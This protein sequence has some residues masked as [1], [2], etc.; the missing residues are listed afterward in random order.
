MLSIGKLTGPASERYYVSKV[1]QGLDDYYAGRGEAPGRWAGWA[2][3]LLMETDQDVTPEQLGAMLRGQS[4]TTGEVLGNPSRRTVSGFDLTFRAPK[5]VS[6]V[7]GLADQPI[8][9][10]ARDAHDAAVRDALGYLERNA[11]W[12]RR[13]TNGTEHLRGSGFLAAAFR[14]RTSRA[15]DPTLH[16]HVVVANATQAAGRWSTLDGRQLY[17]HAKTAGYLY[18]ATLRAELTRNLGV[19]WEA[20]HNGVADISG[21]PR[22]VIEHFSQR[23]AA[24]L[25]HMAERGEH[26]AR[27]AQIATLA[28]RERKETIAPLD[29]LRDEWR[30]RAAEHGFVRRD[31]DALLDRPGRLMPEAAS[32]DGDLPELTRQ[33]S[34]FDRRHV[35]QAFAERASAVAPAAELE[36]NA[37]AWLDSSRAVALEP[38]RR[39]SDLQRHS[40]PEMI[41]IEQ[42]LMTR[43]RGSRDTG[44][45]LVAAEHVETVLAKRPELSDE[46]ADMTR[47]LTGSGHGIEIV[48]APAGTGK[49][50]ALDAA[51]D[52]WQCE[53]LHVHGCALS[54]RAAAELHDQTG[55]PSTT[56]A[57]LQLDLR[58][59]HQL[60]PD[61]VLVVD[62]AGMV[63]TRDIADLANHAEQANAKLVLCG[64]DRQLPEIAAGGAFRALADRYG[65]IELHEVHRQR[66]DWDR[67]ALAEL[68]TGRVEDWATA[69]REHDRI[70]TGTNAHAVRARLVA[71]WQAARTS[72]PEE[73]AIMLAHRRSDVADLNERARAQLCAAGQL[74]DDELTTA[75]RS[76]AVGDRVITCRN[77]RHVDVINGQRGTV[78]AVDLDR[79]SLTITR[80]DE[81]QVEL[82]DSYLADRHLDHAY[83]MT[84]HRAQGITVDRAFVLG[85]DE[86]YREW[87]YT[88]LS[89]HREE[90]R[91]YVNV[92]ND[93]PT[94]DDDLDPAAE[95]LRRRERKTLAIDTADPSYLPDL[96]APPEMPMPEIPSIPDQ[97]DID[98]GLDFGL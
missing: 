3:D 71:D 74:G 98:T 43:A 85:S 36:A 84:A 64:D 23:R 95:T 7:F 91:F 87:G 18:Q 17:R 89:R 61:S 39:P 46:Q 97:L 1:A 28:T 83:A 88:A 57:R 82:P 67:A 69:Y 49:T 16:S 75:G 27:A 50:F 21:I 62:E 29:R 19:E 38:V 70:V 59:G 58:H 8:A 35:L 13:G 37:D 79:C 65:A 53:G 5:S 33:S 11:C 14:H 92:G 9:L 34:T 86:L 77:D 41:A 76:F 12:T 30:A 66:N 90:A 72:H 10:A 54:A 6:L 80:D 96:D 94:L 44:T 15:G 47:Q 48:C 63:G 73:D 22:D 55:I 93:P 78:T 24:I 45:G 52:A 81:T 4:P 56:I 51:R 68:R 42:Q 31:L 26:S 20:V 40:T 2:T 32:H 25:E 60:A